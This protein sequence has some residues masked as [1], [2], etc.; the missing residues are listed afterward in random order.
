MVDAG[1]LASMGSEDRPLLLEI[2]D[3]V[4]TDAAAR[5]A[6]QALMHEFKW[7]AS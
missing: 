7:V 1:F 5:E 2:C 6:V 3:R 4:S